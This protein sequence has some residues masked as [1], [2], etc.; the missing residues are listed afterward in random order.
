M[1]DTTRQA[2]ALT[3]A[4]GLTAAINYTGIAVMAACC[5]QS[6]RHLER[7]TLLGAV[8]AGARHRAFWPAYW[9]SLAALVAG[10]LL[11]LAMLPYW[12]AAVVWPL[13]A[14]CLALN[15]PAIPFRLGI[16]VAARERPAPKGGPTQPNHAD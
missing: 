6:A 16:I 11:P 14:G 15:W 4:G 12:P 7:R 3:A 2:A 8:R 13:F 5:G 1:G 9:I 10:S